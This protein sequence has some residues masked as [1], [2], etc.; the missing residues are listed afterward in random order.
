[1]KLL[2]KITSTICALALCV[3]ASAAVSAQQL[4]VH[5]D[6]GVAVASVDADVP[7]LSYLKDVAVND[8]PSYIKFVR[9]QQL[10]GMTDFSSLVTHQERFNSFNKIYGIDVSQFNGEI[11]FTKVKKE[12]YQFVIVRAGAR[13]YG[14]SGMMISDTD[15]EK[16]I[17]NAK[18]AGLMVGVY[19]YTQAIT[20]QEVKQEADFCIKKIAGRKLD[21]PVYFDIEPAYDWTGLPGRLVAAKFSK[22]KKAELCQYF[23]DLIQQA[24]YVGGITSCK[25]WFDNEIEMSVLEN[26]YDI[27]LAHY[28]ENTNYSSSYN[29]WQFA[30]TRKIEGVQSN[31]TDQ[32]VRYIDTVRPVGYLKLSAKALSDTVILNWN[33]VSNVDGYII[34]KKDASGKAVKIAQ[35][36]NLS[37]TIQR[38]DSNAMYYVQAF[39]TVDSKTYYSGNSNTVSVSGAKVTGIKTLSTTES[40]V[41]LSWNAVTGA[42]GYVVYI[43]NGG[44]TTLAGTTNSTNLTV[45]GLSRNVEYTFTVYP[46]Y[47]ADGSKQF[48]QGVSATAKNADPFKASTVRDVKVNSVELVGYDRYE[49]AALISKQTFPKGTNTVV[50]ATGERYEDALVAAPMARAY[51]A[52]VLLTSKND[53]RAYTQAEIKRLGAKKVYVVGGTDRLSGNI[54]KA[55][56]SMG[57]EVR[58]V[59]SSFTND[60]FGTAVYVS[61]NMD[62][63]RG[64]TPTEVFIST[65]ECYADMLSI[66]GIAAAKNAPVLYI[67]SNGII[68]GATKFY[69][70]SIRSGL[71]N[72]YIIGGTEAI[73]ATADKML[74]EYCTNVTRIGGKNRYETCVMVNKYFD[75]VLT[76]SSLCVTTGAEFPDA[77][78]GGAFAAVNKAPVFIAD[79]VLSDTQKQ[80]L[81]A[82]NPL[83]LYRLGGRGL[84]STAFINAINGR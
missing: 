13:G 29:M 24:G 71:K 76:G 31:C 5:T 52:P 18:K 72:V 28:T 19:Y 53:L 66:A 49:T 26:K 30:S 16:N 11:D 25:S 41:S 35:T 46:Y 33:A 69:L 77:M 2:R 27:W 70:N 36:K 48:K 84:D 12:G 3:Q 7:C 64:S 47:N 74:K 81:K 43:A 14:Q 58:R 32:D 60:D 54:D 55:L 75:S 37:Y 78:A 65:V 39:N 38:S 79:R 45:S 56:E 9:N 21:L 34:Y 23:C 80:Y 59:F 10:V 15:F 1:M 4:G 83:K 63:V 67:A 42:A 51:N 57:C 62:I 8:D 40:S 50:L 73:G 61:A 17:D 44:K 82:K 68:D 22:A 6:S 20:K